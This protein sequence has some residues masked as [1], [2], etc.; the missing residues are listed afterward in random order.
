MTATGKTTATR[1]DEHGTGKEQH[2]MSFTK[3]ILAGC[4]LTVAALL[5]SIWAIADSARPVNASPGAVPSIVEALNAG[6][7][8]Y[9]QS[10]FAED[11]V[12]QGTPGC[13]TPCVGLEAIRAE[14]ENLA[15]DNTRYTVI[16]NSLMI[17]HVFMAYMRMKV[18]SDS[19]RAA[20][21]ER[22]L[23]TL[24]TDG[25]FGEMTSF[26][27]DFDLTDPQTVDYLAFLEA[28][29]TGAPPTHSQAAPTHVHT[30]VPT[31][32][33]MPTATASP[34]PTPTATA[35]QT[36]TGTAEPTATPTATPAPAGAPGSSGGNGVLLASTIIPIASALV[37]GGPAWYAWRRTGG[38]RSQ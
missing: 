12:L 35:T 20:V 16:D 5:A 15:S 2:L 30:A 36:A 18:T 34:T 23:V 10:T 13:L 7:F 32:T 1:R 22:I 19:I 38:R 28:Q 33:P 11:A 3:R 25:T 4:L 27:I 9:V 31:S 6:D 21:V 14:F 37:L 26:I 29:A 24:T 17:F 8:N